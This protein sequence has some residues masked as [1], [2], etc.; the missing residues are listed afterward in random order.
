[1]SGVCVCE[2]VRQEKAFRSLHV[3]VVAVCLWMSI[4]GWSSL[5]VIGIM[6]DS[7]AMGHEGFVDN[8]CVLCW[9]TG[10]SGPEK[11]N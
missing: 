5:V 2:C 9:Q 10:V 7:V 6:S 11:V 8:A 3:S 1:M 4:H